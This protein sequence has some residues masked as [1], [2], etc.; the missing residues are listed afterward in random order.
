[1]GSLG[2]PES[3]VVSPELVS[4]FSQVEEEFYLTELG[5][6]RWYLLVIAALV[7]GP[8]PEL[9]DQ[10]YLYLINR[11][12]YSS[13]ATRHVLIRRLREALVKCVSIVGVC[14]P[15]EAIVAIA[16]VEQ[17]EDK[18]YTFTRKAWQCDQ[19]N[20]DRGMDWLRQV[21]TRNA[22]FTLGLFEAHKDFAWISSEIT[23]GL[24]LSDRQVLDD[25]DTEVVVLPGIMIQNLK[26]ET[27][28]HIRGTRRI[29]VSQQDVQRIW[30]CVQMVSKY[31]NTTLDR[32]PTVKEVEHDV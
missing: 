28:W 21:Y 7:G 29:G 2:P 26:T 4:L 27:H 18:D 31:L 17:E 22:D 12:R 13:T 1:M 14:R 24:Y 10:L 15:L 9:A 30:N 23:Y 11:P 8:E 5:N 16:K 3:S 25:I 32:V 20:H 19:T 6:D